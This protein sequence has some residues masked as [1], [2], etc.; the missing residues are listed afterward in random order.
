MTRK[1]RV[2]WGRWQP[3]MDRPPT[4][5]YVRYGSDRQ[6]ATVLLL[7]VEPA[8]KGSYT[9]EVYDKSEAETLDGGRASSLAEGKLLADQASAKWANAPEDFQG[10]A[11]ARGAVSRQKLPRAKGREPQV[12]VQAILKG[13]KEQARHRQVQDLRALSARAARGALALGKRGYHS[14]RAL[15][16]KA[17]SRPR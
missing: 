9:W 3:T 11:R 2:I 12:C 6:G 16:Q 13:A 14:S 17:K 5:R 4:G 8:G 15:I 7:L 10:R 1:R